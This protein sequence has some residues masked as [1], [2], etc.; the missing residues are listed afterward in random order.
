MIK[1]IARFISALFPPLDSRLSSDEIHGF[2]PPLFGSVCRLCKRGKD[3]LFHY[4]KIQ[5]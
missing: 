2:K 5:V 1:L 4:P 3:S